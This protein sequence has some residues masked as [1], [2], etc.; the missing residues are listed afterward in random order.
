MKKE[1]LAQC[2]P[3]L[4]EYLGYMET[5]RGRSESAIN[6]YFIDLRTFLRFM[7]QLRGLVPPTLP[8]AEIA[9]LDVDI[10]FLATITLNDVYEYMN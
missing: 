2:P 1:Y 9:I 3:I 6:E 10:P 7:K 5:I 4:K 8:E